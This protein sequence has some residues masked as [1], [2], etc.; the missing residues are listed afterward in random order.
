MPC[1]TTSMDGTSM[2][3]TANMDGMACIELYGVF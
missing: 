2:D 3:G 1:V